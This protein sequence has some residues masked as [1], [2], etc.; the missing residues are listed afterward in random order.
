MYEALK[1]VKELS[2]VVLVKK[3]LEDVW[4]E[5]KGKGLNRQIDLDLVQS[6]ILEWNVFE[7]EAIVVGE[8]CLDLFRHQLGNVGEELHAGCFSEGGQWIFEIFWCR[9]SLEKAL[10]V[11]FVEQ[12]VIAVECD[13]FEILINSYYYEKN[14]YYKQIYYF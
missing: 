5:E 12:M 11:A 13:S 4:L 1:S 9:D 10:E 3:L 6:N 8:I 7:Q 2:L 14:M